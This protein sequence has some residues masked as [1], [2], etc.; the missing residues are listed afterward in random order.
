MRLHAKHA[1]L[2]LFVAMAA[3]CLAAQAKQPKANQV[4]RNSATPR[5][6]S[7]THSFTSTDG[8]AILGA[9][10]DSRHRTQRRPDCS[11]FV[12]ELYEQAGF[13][14]EYASSSDLYDGVDQFQRV[15]NPQPGDLAVWRGH[16]GI[17][18]NPR[19]HSFFSLL[20]S[21]P[22]VDLYDSPYWKRRGSP[23]F[24]RYVKAA[25]SAVPRSPVQ[26]ANWKRPVQTDEDDLS[27]DEPVPDESE[28]LPVETR[29]LDLAHTQP[30]SMAPRAIVVNA[31]KPRPDQV[32]AA[33]L[34]ACK[35]WEQNLR[36]RDLFKS[37]QALVVFDHFEVRKLHIAGNQ[38]WVE[39]Q[40][41]E[42]VSLKANSADTHKR[43]KH[44]R[45][46]LTRRENKTWEL[47][48]AP[49][50]IY[51]PQA[52]AVR[53]LATELADLTVDPA[54][55]TQQKAQLARLLNVLLEK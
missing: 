11:H 36:G 1:R 44:Q 37:S 23:R 30:E 51:L 46:S 53:L 42:P 32:S 25:P 24:F 18:V 40:I 2:L 41:E 14:Y 8:L 15:A 26:N 38:G 29:S 43:T 45:W 10:L 35:D 12:H 33:F 7:G 9:A 20:R 3:T 50:T 5:P 39:V 49:N 28:K 19:Q 4:T 13:S 27:G 47:T 22:G 48:P 21:G 55:N 31:L 16:V 54:N 17:V 34:E 6:D 52:V